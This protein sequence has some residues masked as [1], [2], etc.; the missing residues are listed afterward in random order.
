MIKRVAIPDSHGCYIDKVAAAAVIADIK[1]IKPDEV[2][3]L[4][5]H[6]DA[7]GLF[8]KFRAQ[9]I[10]DLDYTYR[11]DIDKAK[12][13]IAQVRKAAPKA[14]IYYLEGNHEWHVER[15]IA[16]TF[17]PSEAI[18]ATRAF[19]PDVRLGLAGLGIEYIRRSDLTIG[20]TSRG[21]LSLDGCYF[22]H[23]ISA[24][25]WATGRHLDVFGANVCHGHTHRAVSV[26]RR[27]PSG[28]VIGGYCPGT[29]AQFAPL[30]LH[31]TPDNW[32]HG[33]GLQFVDKGI[34]HHYN[35]AIINGKTVLP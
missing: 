9:Y 25:L 27:R 33:Y 18:D 26:V 28:E 29:L 14:K 20:T 4:G 16:T 6:V 12:D 31:T 24:S 15:W 30:Y 7:S 32:T 17:S 21:V 13:F 35:V 1:R 3:F 19:G 23:G 34:L 10:R 22:V 2:V 8:S 11:D 5:D